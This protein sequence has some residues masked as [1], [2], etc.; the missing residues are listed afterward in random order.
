[1]TT[2]KTTLLILAIL[3]ALTACANRLGPDRSQG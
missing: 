1:M 3:L 2:S